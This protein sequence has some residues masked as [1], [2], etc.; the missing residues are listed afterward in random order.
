MSEPFLAAPLW[1]RS[2]AA[3]MD[4]FVP[5]TV[6][7]LGTWVLVSTDPEPLELPPWNLFDQLV[8][9]LHDRPG[10]AA[11]ALVLWLGTQLAWPLAFAGRTP[12]KRA[13]GLVL[14]GGD[15]R[16][17]TRSRVARWALLRLPSLALAGLGGW[18]ALVDVERRTLHDR[19]ARLWLVRDRPEHGLRDGVEPA[20][21]G[22]G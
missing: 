7:L 13:L 2:L 4:L 17:A 19:L 16:A 10:R 18:W 11:L 5:L 15:G 1:R 6:W 14:I 9:Y 20:G 21:D 12:G 22:R 3:L 8:D